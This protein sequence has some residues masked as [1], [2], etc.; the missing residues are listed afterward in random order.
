[1]LLLFP[2]KCTTGVTLQH[3]YTLS[4]LDFGCDRWCNTGCLHSIPF[5]S[6]LLGLQRIA[7]KLCPQAVPIRLSLKAIP[8]VFEK[9][10][11]EAPALELPLIL[12][13][14]LIFRELLC[15]FLSIPSVR[16]EIQFQFPCG[17]SQIPLQSSELR[18]CVREVENQV[19]ALGSSRFSY[20]GR[21]P[22][23]VQ[24]SGALCG[25]VAPRPL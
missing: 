6:S 14:T 16:Y 13:P 24:R 5:S 9:A 7:S 4:Y 3:F 15:H 11:Q 17:S 20:P 21:V 18:E 2:V 12:A 1:M 8:W 10:W 19:L 25:P 22:S 23:S